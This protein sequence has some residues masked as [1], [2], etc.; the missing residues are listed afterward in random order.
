MG[1]SAQPE[2]SRLYSE[3]SQAWYESGDYFD[4][5]SATVNNNGAEVAVHYHTFGNRNN[6]AI[7]M[8]HGF[9]TS[10]F[11]FREMIDYLDED[12]FIATLDFPGFGF[13]DK[14]QDGYNYMLADDA[15]LADY[16]IREIVEIEDFALFTHD[17][18]VSVGLAFLG[19]YLDSDDPG[20]NINYHF[21]SNS[22]M[23]LPLANLTERQR[24]MQNVET[25]AAATAQAKARPR[26]T[27]GN[28]VQVAYADMEAF[29]DGIGARLYVSRYLLERVANEYKWL[30]NLPRS[31]LPVA[32]IWGVLDP[33]NPIRTANY[34]WAEY[35]NDREVE[36]S[37]WIMP[38]GGHYPQRDRPQEMAKIVRFALTSRIPDVENE[39][40]FMWQWSR[41][42]TEHDAIFVGH[43]HIEEMSFPGSLQYTPEGYRDRLGEK[44]TNL[45]Q[46]R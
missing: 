4:W 21:L 23:F 9:P 40:D 8:L 45:E 31:P 14:P 2:N 3:L 19:N 39:N 26:R 6:P 29:N 35:L 36:S 42:R 28:P 11:D 1:I 5:A 30:D 16:F 37:F 27:E 34:V 17:R 33:V 43:S 25:A 13:S 15:R 7:V 18:G 20:Y 32:Y 10:S 44:M 46:A 41:Q 22:G 24:L 38:T 12:Y